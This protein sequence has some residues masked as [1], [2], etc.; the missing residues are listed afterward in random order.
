MK[1]ILILTG[2]LVALFA[3]LFITLALTGISAPKATQQQP[4]HQNDAYIINGQPAEVKYFGNEAVHDFN[5]DGILDRAYLV[6]YSPG[7]S[8]T[9]Y[10]VVA[11]LNTPQGP[12]NS[13]LYLLG[14]RIAPQTTEIAVVGSSTQI[15]VNYADRA[16][17]DSFAV[18]PSIGKTIRLILDP[19]TMKFGIVAN[20]FEG[21]SR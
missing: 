2:V 3:I 18:A 4:I 16:L 12:I 5:G 14:D 17:T 11:T 20:N 8:G 1:K 21:E 7:G 6:T 15:I 10:Y 9:F 19:A 13:E